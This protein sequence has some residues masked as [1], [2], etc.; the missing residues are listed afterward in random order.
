MKTLVLIIGFIFLLLCGSAI[1]LTVQY[2]LTS[3]HHP[4]VIT[5]AT[6]IPQ[7]LRE[8]SLENLESYQLTTSQIEVLEPL[9]SNNS[10]T[11]AYLFWYQ[12]DWGKVSGRLTLPTQEPP[13]GI[14][15]MARGYVPP[16]IYQPGIGT[17]RAAEFY[18][19]N[20]YITLA[21]DFLGFGQSDPDLD[22]TWQARFIKPL[23]II[24]LYQ[25]L[26]TQLQFSNT[27]LEIT[28]A[29]IDTL[30]T[31]PT[32]KTSQKVAFWGHSNG[33]QIMLSALMGLSEPVPTTLWAPVTAPF[34]YS[35]LFF[36]DE[37]A[38]EGL[39]TRKWLSLFEDVYDVREFSLTQHLDLLT[40]SI[41][42]HHGTADDAALHT[43]S[44]EFAQKIQQENQRRHEQE[45]TTDVEQINLELISYP[46]ADHN[47]QPNWQTVVQQDLVFF[48]KELQ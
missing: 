30:T 12:T 41:Q 20:G 16:S 14:I 17:N 5:I 19:Q 29:Q 24:Q 42:I 47:L 1:T 25:A 39:E 43:W 10:E 33:G 7:P 9:S 15:I 34:P 36:S 4:P 31:I 32:L 46:G 37:S 6:P 28:P 3:S 35:I 26:E 2:Y 13:K 38:D 23:Q 8:F 18:S 27:N 11:A 21:P 22:D 45:D 48:E 44:V 40:G